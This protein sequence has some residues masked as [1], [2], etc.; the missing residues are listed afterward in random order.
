VDDAERIGRALS[1]PEGPRRVAIYG[2]GLIAAETASALHAQGHEVSLISRSVLPGVSAFGRHVAEHLADRH[3]SLVGTFLGRTIAVLRT[4]EDHLVVVLD[5]G[6]EIAVDLAILA[7]GTTPLG[8]EPW[9]DGVDVDDRLRAHDVDGVLA[10]GGVAVHHDD[11]LGRWRIDHWEDAAAQG[12]H[13]AR[14]LLHTIDRGEDPGPYR[15]RSAYSATIYGQLVAG[16]GHTGFPGTR[17]ERSGDLLV[18]HEQCG[19]VVGVSGVDVVG[20]VYGWGP[21]LHEARGVAAGIELG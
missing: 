8:P 9:V 17:A 14:M 1:W 7:L 3:A 6:S 12:A 18:L 15:P 16:A 11:H 13:A 5:D 21:R 10:A 20:E 4:E 19:S 2:A